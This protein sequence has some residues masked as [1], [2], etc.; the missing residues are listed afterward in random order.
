MRI[1]KKVR[2]Y[3]QTS[4][5][6]DVFTTDFVRLIKLRTIMTVL[7]TRMDMGL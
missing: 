1:S 7:T 2:K 3:S 4:W 6:Y 5:P